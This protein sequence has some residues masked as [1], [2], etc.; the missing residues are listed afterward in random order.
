M[1]LRILH[2]TINIIP[3]VLVE[4]GVVLF[5]VAEE[6]KAVADF[7]GVIVQIVWLPV[8]LEFVLA[9]IMVIFYKLIINR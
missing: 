7:V 6:K 3:E 8:W 2:L 5:A 4:V 1:K 9:A